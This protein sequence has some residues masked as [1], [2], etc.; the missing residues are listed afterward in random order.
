MKCTARCWGRLITKE[1]SPFKPEVKKMSYDRGDR[2]VCVA[3]RHYTMW[4]PFYTGVGQ[5]GTRDY[6]DRGDRDVCV[7]KRH[8]TMWGP[9]YT[10][11]GQE[12]TED[13]DD[14]GVC[15]ALTTNVKLYKDHFRVVDTLLVLK[16]KK[17]KNFMILVFF[18]SLYF[19]NLL[20]QQHIFR[21]LSPYRPCQRKWVRQ[22]S[23]LVAFRAATKV[24][25]RRRP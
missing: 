7:T 18:V 23:L 3:K 4:G 1:G 2:D 14:R 13:Y 19:L 10:G 20:Q 9:F 25:R 5:E 12:G 15:V 22:I 16:K 21:D 6:D 17:E 8:D 11:V 24:G